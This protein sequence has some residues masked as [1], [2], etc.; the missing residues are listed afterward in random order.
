MLHFL[1]LISGLIQQFP[2]RCDL[3]WKSESYAHRTRFS[4][5]E[6]ISDVKTVDASPATCEQMLTTADEWST[7][8]AAHPAFSKKCIFSLIHS[9][10]KKE[11][12]KESQKYCRRRTGKHLEMSRIIS[13]TRTWLSWKARN[14]NKVIRGCSHVLWRQVLEN[15]QTGH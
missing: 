12:Q 9:K 3:K 5:W 10:R 6:D 15:L 13:I 4:I 11:K 8:A 7:A 14:E 1:S 2:R